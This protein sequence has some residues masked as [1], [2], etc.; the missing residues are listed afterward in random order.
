MTPSRKSLTLYMVITAL[1]AA[2]TMM[3]GVLK[4][5]S[6]RGGGEGEREM[7]GRREM[8]RWE[9]DDNSVY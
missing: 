9:T 6:E 1:G 3:M 4:R 2:G 7:G 8:V 5:L